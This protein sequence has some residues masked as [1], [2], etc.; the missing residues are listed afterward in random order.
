MSAKK[1]A[2]K[3]EGEAGKKKGGKKPFFILLALLLL[4]GGGGAGLWFTGILPSLLGMGPKEEAAETRA[5][6][7]PRPV[8]PAPPV[9]YDLPEIVTN[10][11][12]PGRRP[13]FI[14]LRSKLELVRSED[15]KP[16]EAAMPRLMDI[17]QTYLREVRPEELRGSVGTYRLREELLA[18][19]N[20]VATPIRVKDVLFIEIIVQ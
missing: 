2:K 4:L 7:A 13:T 14:K 9:F 15:A 8:P 3:T 19:A 12:V 16:I 1:A 18:R 20:L 10:L 11:N 5:A 17:F 6:E